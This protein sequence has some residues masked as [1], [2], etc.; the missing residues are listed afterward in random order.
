MATAPKVIAVTLRSNRVTAARAGF[1]GSLS[2]GYA[3]NADSIDGIGEGGELERGQ[4]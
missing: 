1:M 4:S 2:K 3:L